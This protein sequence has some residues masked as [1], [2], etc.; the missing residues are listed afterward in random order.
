MSESVGNSNKPV[1]VLGAAFAVAAIAALVFFIKFNEAKTEAS[2]AKAQLA[3][4]ELKIA[5]LQPLADKARQMPI[6]TKFQKM[7][8][9][10]FAFAVANNSHK[11]LNLKVN[12]TRTSKAQ[13]FSPAVEPGKMWLLNGLILGEEVGVA[14]EGY[15][16]QQLTVQ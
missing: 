8:D 10:T 3:Q 7:K 13:T 11:T 14:C 2:Q 12:V 4:D 6:V 15:E 5:E 1:I 9:G 16:T